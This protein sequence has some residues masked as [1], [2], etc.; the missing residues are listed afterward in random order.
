MLL[1]INPQNPEQRK[2]QQVVDTLNEGGIIVYPTDTVYGLGCDI[3][4]P[5][6]VE[7]I[8]RLRGLD[9]AKAMLSLFVVISA[10]CPTSHFR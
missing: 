8:C 4:Q 7:K 10:K 3:F 6:A 1:K 2:I 5:K 9:P